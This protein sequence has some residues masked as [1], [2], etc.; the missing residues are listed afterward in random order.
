MKVNALSSLKIFF[1]TSL[2]VSLLQPTAQAV[3]LQ[4]E[5][6]K[7]SEPR[8]NYDG[9][10]I[11]FPAIEHRLP[12]V[13]SQ[14]Q[15]I[16][17]VDFPDARFQFGDVKSYLETLANPKNL[18]EFYETMS[19]G[20]VEIKFDI[21]PEVI[22]LSKPFSYYLQNSNRPYSGE[23]TL[24][25][26]AVLVETR[27]FLLNKSVLQKYSAVNVVETSMKATSQPASA[28]ADPGPSLS[29]YPNASSL[30]PAYNN[31]AFYFGSYYYQ[32]PRDISMVFAHEIGHLFGFT[33]IYNMTDKRETIEYLKHPLDTMGL[34]GFGLGAWNR[35]LMGWVA[36]S[37]VVCLDE[38]TNVYETSISALNLKDGLKAIVIRLSPKEVLIVEARR[39]DKYDTFEFD[40]KN[41]NG[42]AIHH[43]DTSIRSGKGAMKIYY[44]EELAVPVGQ[45]DLKILSMASLAAK[46]IEADEYL[47]YKPSNILIENLYSDGTNNQ[48][49]ISFGESA[50]T[51][52]KKAKAKSEAVKLE[53]AAAELK[54][55]QE[56]EAQK[57][58]EAEEKAAAELKAKQE[59]EAQL[60]K[61]RQEAI[62]ANTFYID[63]QYCHSVG[64]NAE[65][66]VLTE[67][68]WLPLAQPKGWVAIP[69]CPNSQPVRPWTI[70]NLQNSEQ[71]RW[72]RWRF[73]VDGKWNVVGNQFQSLVSTQAK[74]EALARVIA[75]AKAAAELNAKQEAEA[76]AKAEAANKKVTITCVKGK[77]VKKVTAVKPTCPKGYKK[78]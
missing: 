57:Q 45:G 3:P 58:K 47:Y 69:S 9:I 62:L 49:R 54:A 12:R 71:I 29:L 65:L 15:L 22:T 60:L 27:E 74:A 33:D 44:D 30:S 46:I 73:W 18:S 13:G 51:N 67:G 37:Q 19:Y 23:N 36:D 10:S 70:V 41:Y 7:L 25:E 75:Q 53:K 34:L 31:M 26:G 72:L 1:I 52:L 64:I 55:K 16:V 28:M 14:I 8:T 24:S 77:A 43:L 32:G 39:N 40:F 21:Y 2:L 59:A 50:L 68:T 6:C 76:R 17:A 35:W 42:L 78:K 38:S 66:Q 63:S 11:S 5:Q 61:E 4:I 48:V 20:K 56:A